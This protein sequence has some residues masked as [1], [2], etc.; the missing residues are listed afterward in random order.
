VKLTDSAGRGRLGASGISAAYAEKVSTVFPE[1]GVINWSAIHEAIR[2][3]KPSVVTDFFADSRLTHWWG[4]ARAEGVRSYASF[5]LVA[6]ERLL[7]VLNVYFRSVHEY[8]PTEV[9]L[10]R[11]VAGYAASAIESA[12]LRQERDRQL[13]ALEKSLHHRRLVDDLHRAV[14]ASALK[15][16]GAQGA[17]QVLTELL[18]AATLLEDATG[19]VIRTTTADPHRRDL[20]RLIT[21]VANWS[22]AGNKRKA[23]PAPSALIDDLGGS[24][25]IYRAPVL[26][27]ESIAGAVWMAV[28]SSVASDI[29]HQAVEYTALAIALDLTGKAMEEQSIERA[30]EDVLEGVLT[31]VDDPRGAIEQALRL[32][33]QLSPPFQVVLA[34]DVTSPTAAEEA[35]TLVS[36]LRRQFAEQ[37]HSVLVTRRGG[38]A[39][40]VFCGSMGSAESREP[41]IRYLRTHAQG[42]IVLGMSTDSVGGLAREW[43]TAARLLELGGVSGLGVEVIDAQRIGIASLIVESS[44]PQRLI[45]FM[46]DVLGPLIAYDEEHNTDLLLSLRA[47]VDADL[48]VKTAAAA[49]VVHANTLN[50]RIR[51]IQDITGRD[52]RSTRDALD[53]QLALLIQQIASPR[54]HLGRGELP[55]VVTQPKRGMSGVGRS[56]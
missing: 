35:R 36:R 2:T 25:D 6:E 16:E 5:P 53:I 54:S 24:T 48:R 9:A 47:L 42:P 26:I 45:Q 30:F 38:V 7:G 13:A 34:G 55:I 8:Q 17:L 27:E 23:E 40:I 49:L 41:W 4:I 12:I 1:H 50:Y 44:E 37:T 39:T 14:T 10:I 18:G 51:R 46:D 56:M 3:G 28:E 32:G 11:A 31:A 21:R 43:S 19:R 29:A 22:Q 15:R 20:R 33:C 52:L